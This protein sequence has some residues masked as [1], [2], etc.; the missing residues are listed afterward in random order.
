[1]N[2]ILSI[3]LL[4]LTRVIE[5][6]YANPFQLLFTFLFPGGNT[7]SLLSLSFLLY[8]IFFEGRGRKFKVIVQK[9]RF[10]KKMK[11]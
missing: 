10:Y 1:M 4:K 11:S 3:V 7:Y 5:S 2:V 8:G 6:R 9:N